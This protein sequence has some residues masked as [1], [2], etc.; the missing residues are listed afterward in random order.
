VEQPLGGCLDEIAAFLEGYVFFGED[1]RAATQRDVT[2]LWIAHTY[3]YGW[4]Q[5]SPRLWVQS[6][7]KASGKTTLVSC[8]ELLVHQP[9]RWIELTDAA[10][11]RRAQAGP[12]TFLLDEIDAIFGSQGTDRRGLRSALNEAYKLGA[13]IPRVN[14]HGDVEEFEIYAPVAFA[15]LGRAIPATL[16]SR[17]IEIEP[18]KPPT[19][20]AAIPLDVSTHRR[21]AEH[22]AALLRDQLANL[23]SDHADAIAHRTVIV[24]DGLTDRAAELWRPLLAIAQHAGGRWAD[25]G[26]AAARR[27]APGARDD[28]PALQLLFDL[29]QVFDRNRKDRLPSTRIISELLAL[30]DAPWHEW[31]GGFNATVL[32]RLLHPFRIGRRTLRFDGFQAK[33]YR[34]DDFERAWTSYCR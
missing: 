7:V 16:R 31:P 22:Q 21:V 2:V 18:W 29:R 26:D 11:F 34:R 27:L 4:L 3:I 30:D 20:H 10:F 13:R 25:R 5:V 6:P 23:T 32:A 17:A 19:G 15:G 12:A 24:P 14:K 28:E 1:E 9:V 8:L 33:G